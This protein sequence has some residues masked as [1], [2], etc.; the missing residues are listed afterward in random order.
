MADKKQHISKNIKKVDAIVTWLILWGVIASIY[1]LSKDKKE[2]ILDE[3]GEE[4]HSFKKILRLLVFGMP[5]EKPT[6]YQR[7]KR[8]FRKK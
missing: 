7:I 1:G 5:K 3:N 8:I 4:K 6:F 2:I